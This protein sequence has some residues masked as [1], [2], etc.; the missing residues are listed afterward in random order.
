MRF[1]FPK[2]SMRQSM[3]T[4]QYSDGWLVTGLAWLEAATLMEVGIRSGQP[5]HRPTTS[6]LKSAQPQQPRKVL[7][8][9]VAIS[10]TRSRSLGRTF[11]RVGYNRWAI[12][13]RRNL[14]GDNCSRSHR[15]HSESFV[16]ISFVLPAM[17]VIMPNMRLEKDRSEA[18]SQPWRW[19]LEA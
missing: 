15:N 17:S 19:A 10:G 1:F 2:E 12:S 14:D 8:V 18:T 4:S 5:L 13:T 7:R 6:I 16:N 11:N 9:P 3:P